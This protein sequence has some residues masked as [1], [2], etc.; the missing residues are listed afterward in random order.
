MKILITG[1]AGY[2]GSKLS[3]LLQNDLLS[4]NINNVICSDLREVPTDERLKGYF[5]EQA[6]IT[7]TDAID[8]IFKKHRPDCIVHLA[9]VLDSQSMP[10]A[11]QYKIDVDGL[12]NILKAAI[13]YQ[14]KRIIISSSG[15]AY[16]YYSDNPEWLKE[17]DPVR[18]N[19]IFAY[20]DHKRIVEEILAE[21]R[22]K[23]PQ[24]EQTIFRIGTILGD[25]TD[26]L[27][28]KLFD[29][30][31]ILG[32]RGFISP[33]V[34]IWDEDASACL[35]QAIFSEKTGIFNLAGDGAL[36]NRDLAKILGKP[37]LELPP[38]L[39]K[40]ALTI[41]RPLGLSK[42]GPEQLLFL[43]YRPVLDNTKL[44]ED[45]E[46]SP[47]KTSLQTFCYYLQSKK[48]EPKNLEKVKIMTPY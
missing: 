16:G 34:F 48:I 10:R 14:S 29:K 21:Y 2:L 30:K 38:L 4:E 22:E 35:R 36:R 47:Q 17:D 24:L 8:L 45:F 42:Y 3:K 26:N 33:F 6:D 1:A 25:N 5:Y 13:K 41:L 39:L 37:Y 15:A 28:T 7:D 11:L 18:G 40:L 20:S 27:I 32:L 31:R 44:K 19:Q 12:K 46:F 23:E 9:A 43:Q